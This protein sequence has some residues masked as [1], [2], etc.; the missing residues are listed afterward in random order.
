MTKPNDDHG[1]IAGPG[2]TGF[3]GSAGYNGGGAGGITGGY[4][5]EGYS[6]EP[7]RPV[8]D[9]HHDDRIRDDIRARLE[10]SPEVDAN[11]IQVGVEAGVVTLEGHVE[12]RAMKRAA[13]QLAEVP[14]VLR[15]QNQLHVGQPLFELLRQKLTSR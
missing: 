14:G 5:G 4:A 15:I 6:G 3:G 13:R 1:I 9:T 11:D 8:P 12:T 10:R 7:W 2:Y